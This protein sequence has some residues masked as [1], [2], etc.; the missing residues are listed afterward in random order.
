M[1]ATVHPGGVNDVL[2][3]VAGG[4]GGDPPGLFDVD[5][6]LKVAGL[7]SVRVWE[8]EFDALA[9]PKRESILT[10]AALVSLVDLAVVDVGRTLKGL[11]SLSIPAGRPAE[12]RSRPTCRL[13]VAVTLL[14]KMPDVRQRTKLMLDLAELALVVMVNHGFEHLAGQNLNNDKLRE[15][16]LSAFVISGFREIEISPADPERELPSRVD[17]RRQLSLKTVLPGAGVLMPGAA[18]D[19]TAQILRRLSALERRVAAVV[20]VGCVA[21]VQA[22]PYRVRVNVNTE[23]APVKTGWVPVVI[24]RAGPEPGSLAHSPLSVGEVVL[25]VSPGGSNDVSFALGSVPSM[26]RAP[27]P[28]DAE[29]GKTYYKGDLDVVGDVAIDGDL[30]V[31][32]DISAEGDISADGNVS[33]GDNVDAGGDV[34]AGT[35]ARVRLLTHVHNPPIGGPPQRV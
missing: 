11:G 16:G 2:E 15:K 3:R 5:A 28:E 19:L 34:I 14:M 27:A 30:T 7:K 23:A 25:L 31:T 8:G 9:G 18:D 22:D 10:P 20:R 32:G 17:V 4:A 24:P 26:R 33:A 21:A 1:T 12:S 6:G 13:E 29:E 35:G